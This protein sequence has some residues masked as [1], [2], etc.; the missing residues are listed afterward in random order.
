MRI[1]LIAVTLA[2]LVAT[3]GVLSAFGYLDTNG[4][5]T[6]LPGYNAISLG[7]GGAKAVGF[8][9]ALSV[10]TN[11]ADIYRIPGTS[12]TVS[13]G[14][15]VIREM[16]EDSLGKHDRTW[17]TLGNLSGGMKLQVST[18][19]AFAAGVAEVSDFSYDGQHY[20]YDQEEGP[21]YGQ[22][23]EVRTL[24]VTGGLWES[25]AGFGWRPA[26]W[27]NVGLS[28]GLRFGSVSYDST[29]EDRRDPENDTLVGW[30]LDESE[31][32]WH[33]G[34][35]LPL[36]LAR[37]GLCYTSG[38]DHYDASVAGGALIYTDDA[39][40]AAFGAEAELTDPGDANALTVRIL[41]QFAASP[42]FTLRGCFFFMDR[43]DEVDREG[44][45]IAA[46]TSI[47]LGK[48]TLNGGYH[49]SSVDRSAVAFGYESPE[50]IK[51]SAS[52]VSFGV[53]WNP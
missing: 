11:P 52:I 51:D 19:L 5:G 10:L 38:G 25:A 43:A 41:G 49:W 44:M 35:A 9:D 17:I 28:G 48:V 7:L 27:I 32:A 16:V 53:T 1:S 47:G 22:I 4:N 12:F 3:P 39:R 40:Q 21:E 20:T 36:D 37:I 46:G 2:V 8:G 26:T 15:A 24:K 18:S 13:V 45:G 34:V 31:L 33:A 30:S 14:P 29:F 23:I 6:Q 50:D 42:G